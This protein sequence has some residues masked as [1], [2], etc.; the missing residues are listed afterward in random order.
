MTFVEKIVPLWP[1]G[2]KV[3]AVFEG[4]YILILDSGFEYMNVLSCVC[5][6]LQSLYRRFNATIKRSTE[7]NY[8]DLPH[9][10]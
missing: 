3:C 9:V 5:N 1:I 4:I 7:V 8:F 2:Y 10:C 6:E